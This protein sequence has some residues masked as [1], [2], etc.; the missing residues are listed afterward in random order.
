MKRGDAFPN[1][2]EPHY[3]IINKLLSKILIDADNVY[4]F[5]S[6]NGIKGH[7]ASTTKQEGEFE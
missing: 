6:E 3:I 2:P 5:L 7:C 1:M 4:P